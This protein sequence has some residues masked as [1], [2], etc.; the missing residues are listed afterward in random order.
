MNKTPGW[1]RGEGLVSTRWTRGVAATLALAAPPAQAAPRAAA[2]AASTPEAV[3]AADLP[4]PRATPGGVALVDLGA[5]PSRPSA[6]YGGVPLLVVGSPERWTAL[7]GLALSAAPGPARLSWQATADDGRD[8]D[9]AHTAAFTITAHRYGEQR[10]SVPAKHVDL[11][12]ADLARHERER[13]HQAAVI[14]TF[15]PALPATLR[16]QPPVP[17]ARSSSF[18]LRR[19]FNGQPRNPHSGMD[20][21]A[22]SGTPVRA[23][24]AATVLDTGDYFFNGQTVW[25]D[26]GGG[27]LSMLCHLSRIDVRPGDRLAA[28]D[29]LGAVGATGRVTGPHLHWSVSLNRAMVDPA[30][31]L[32]AEK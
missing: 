6:R 21:A 5:A 25:L 8:V 3:A 2:D 31:F 13:A 20:I 12:P 32:L 11:S 17:G 15:S 27:L 16:M 1:R 7:V 22:A 23:P 9:A 29:V 19:I 30:L 28:G 24:L 14:A 26:H 10:L 18:G 4:Q